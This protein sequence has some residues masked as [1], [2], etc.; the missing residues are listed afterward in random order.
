MI[1]R[2]AAL[3]IALTGPAAA[4]SPLWPPEPFQGPTGEMLSS[5]VET[6]PL[7]RRALDIE[8]VDEGQRMTRVSDLRVS[9]LVV[10]HGPAT[11]VSPRY[12]L[13]LAMFNVIEE[14][15]IA[16][17]LTPIASVWRFHGARRV[18]A[19]RYEIDADLVSEGADC[20]APRYILRLDARSLSAAVRHAE[21]LDWFDSH[22]VEEPVEVVT[23][24]LGCRD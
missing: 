19:G 20:L 9:L 17:S 12:G 22:Q 4:D 18:E 6:V 14:Y 10:D 23:E 7:V 24:R 15:G 16:W 5:V 3:A 8:V 1:A 11:D 2:L 21:G 13:H